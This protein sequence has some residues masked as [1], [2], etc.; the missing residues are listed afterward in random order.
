M[1]YIIKNN[2]GILGKVRSGVKNQK[3]AVSIARRGA[4]KANL[5]HLEDRFFFPIIIRIL[6]VLKLKVV[7]VS[8]YSGA[9]LRPWPDANSI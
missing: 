4:N 6:F 1:N 2:S 8:I 9:C 5:I 3:D 7:R